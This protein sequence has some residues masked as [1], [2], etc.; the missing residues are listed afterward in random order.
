[1]KNW[2]E[3]QHI[4]DRLH[5]LFARGESAALATVVG[6]EGH[7]YRK[8][9][10]KLLIEGDGTLTGNVSGGCLEDD[11]RERALNVLAHGR[12]ETITYDTGGDEDAMW[13]LGMGCNGVITLLLQRLDPSTHAGFVEGARVEFAGDEPLLWCVCRDTSGDLCLVSDDTVLTS[14]RKGVEVATLSLNWV[15]HAIS[16]PHKVVICGAGDDAI[17]L[18]RMANGTGFRVTVVDHRAAYA[19]TDRFPASVRVV[20]QSSDAGCDSLPHDENTLVIVMTH[21]TRHD[22]NWLKVFAKKP[23][24][25]IG[26]LG[27]IDRRNEL[28]QGM[29]K[30]VVRRVHGP[31]GLDIGADG[32]DQIAVSIVAQLLQCV[33]GK[34]KSGMSTKPGLGI[35]TT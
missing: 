15:C 16:P 28:L 22:A 21:A 5:D 20:H 33:H 11:V 31:V 1:M 19:Q 25:Y 12:A 7:S 29:S 23:V 6:V 10:A 30:D 17:P 32:S 14:T 26:L 9:G 27:P 18:S 3:T 35:H 34:L 13:G 4:L 2:N 8:C 24:P